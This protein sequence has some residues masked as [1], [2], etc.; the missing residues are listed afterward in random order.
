MMYAMILVRAFPLQFL[1]FHLHLSHFA[2][3]G[4]L[5]PFTVIK[6]RFES[7]LFNYQSVSHALIQIS[8][9]EGVKVC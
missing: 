8:K 6:A 7:G 5:M 9:K 3:S 1:I 4:V 2:A